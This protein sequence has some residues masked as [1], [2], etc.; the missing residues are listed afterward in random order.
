MKILVTGGY[1]LLGRSLQKSINGEK[2]FFWT[3]KNIPSGSNGI[4]LNILDRINLY[5]L[6]NLYSPDILIN[7]AALTNVDLCEEKP[8][9]AEEVNTVG[10]KN[11]C[12]LF[13]GKIIQISTDYVFSGEKGPYSEEDKVRPISVYG[14]TK[15]K[16]EKII[17]SHNSKNLIIRGN[18]LYDYEKH[19]QASFLNWVIDSL[20]K[21]IPINVVT[22]QINNPT[23][24]ESMA[25]VILKCIESDLSG[26]Y[27]WG[28]AEILSRYEF[29]MK[30]AKRF[31]LNTGLISPILTKNLEQLAPRPLN[32]G[33]KADK[34]LGALDIYQPSVDYCLSKI[35]L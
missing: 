10:V 8:D 20:N 34:L 3:G 15:L 4:C 12:E 33:L 19:S 21:E 32:S 24:T 18:V 28:D 17:M 1:G 13:S 23:W 11:L 29:A 6:I 27:H 2:E 26:V 16:A 35:I 7:L 31:N 25:K 22:D 5:E 14:A 9:L 30:I